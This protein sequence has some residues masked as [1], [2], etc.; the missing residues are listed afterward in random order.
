V[1][2][3]W[4]KD[5]GAF[6][7]AVTAVVA[8][9]V[10]GYLQHKR[11]RRFKTGEWLRQIRMPRYAAFLR[12]ADE[13]EDAIFYTYG[14]P[15]PDIHGPTPKQLPDY[16]AANREF[17]HQLAEVKLVGP[18]EVAGAAEVVQFSLW[19]CGSQLEVHPDRW[20]QRLLSK[21]LDD[22]IIAAK[23]ALDVDSKGSEDFPV[24]DF[25]EWKKS[26]REKD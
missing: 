20:N 2:L 4:I 21:S 1:D 6:V 5:Y 23:K 7:A 17:R 24:P 9:V 18:P 16:N 3:T 22:F 26:L 8:T 25:Q 19:E 15:D 14:I 10:N 12:S 13:Y 11:D